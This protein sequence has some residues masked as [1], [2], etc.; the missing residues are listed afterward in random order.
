MTT[1]PPIAGRVYP[2]LVSAVDEDGNEKAGVRLPEIT[3]PLGTYTGWNLRHPD[4]GGPEQYVRL[5]GS[6]IPFPDTEAARE[7]A[8]DPRPSI[9]ERYASKNDYLGQVR[10]AGQALAD[11][12]FLLAEDLELIIEQ[13]GRRYD[14]FSNHA[15]LPQR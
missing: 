13:L 8:G 5:L 12:G 4:T 2:N 15:A 14:T 9:E 3:V 6:I 1:L 10:S 11:E 7:A